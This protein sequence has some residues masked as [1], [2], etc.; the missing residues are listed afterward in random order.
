MREYRF[1]ITVSVQRQYDGVA[2]FA[3]NEQEAI[4]QAYA[5][6]EIPETDYISAVDIA[7]N[8]VTS[9][10]DTEGHTLQATN[11]RNNW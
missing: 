7:V 4:N 5:L 10:Q 1:N 9:V 3:E 11:S 6:Y 2:V 8:Q